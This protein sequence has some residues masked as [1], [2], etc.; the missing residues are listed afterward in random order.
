MKYIKQLLLIFTLA[1]ITCSKNDTGDELPVESDL[2]FPPISTNEWATTAPEELGWK[3]EK[4]L[5][6]MVLSAWEWEKRR[7]GL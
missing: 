6:E 5:D 2:Y 7:R 1:L 3:T 4:S